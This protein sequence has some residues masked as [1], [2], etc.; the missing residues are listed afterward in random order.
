MSS[1]VKLAWL[2]YVQELVPMM[3]PADF[4]DDAD[5][6]QSFT[7][8]LSLT[9]DKSPDIRKSSRQVVVGLFDLNAATWSLLLRSVPR[10]LQARERKER[11]D[12][13]LSASFL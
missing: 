2:E 3:D 12:K 1:K 9:V 6:R 13:I 11:V 7:K 5:T 10:N 8:L 4:R